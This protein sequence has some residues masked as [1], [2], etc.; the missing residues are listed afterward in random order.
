[1]KTLVKILIIS[2]LCILIYF[3]YYFWFSDWIEEE[4]FKSGTWVQYDIKKNNILH[5]GCILQF[6]DDFL[7]L[8]GDEDC[9]FEFF[10]GNE[11]SFLYYEFQ[12]LI[13]FD[14]ELKFL[15]I[16]PTNLSNDIYLNKKSYSYNFSILDK[17]D[18]VYE[19]HTILEINRDNKS[20]Y[21]LSLNSPW[22][23]S[24]F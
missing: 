24:W 22:W 12:D 4:K 5:D 9:D 18:F 7:T 2:S 14:S 20:I 10:F 15:Q 17:K 1:M 13:L 6:G 3:V 11:E 19:G 21:L 23:F 16:H 8:F